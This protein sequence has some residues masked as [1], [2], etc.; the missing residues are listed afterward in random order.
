V[1][2]AR[3][4]DVRRFCEVDGWQRKADV[5]GRRVSKHEVWVKTLSN[6]ETL[7]TVISK[8]RQTY[9]TGVL[10]A[11]LKRQLRVSETEFWQ[12]VRKAVPPVRPGSSPA[13][14]PG[15]RLP[16]E[17]VSRLLEGGLTIAD[18]RGLSPEQA[19]RL[20]PPE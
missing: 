10:A 18:L 13:P 6:G 17:L 7:R 9:P 16:F 20:A 5:A 12:A 8:G 14:P 11:I 1:K 15:E 2:A 4:S 3:P 19:R